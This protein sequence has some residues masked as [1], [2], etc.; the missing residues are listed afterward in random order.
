RAISSGAG[1]SKTGYTLT[2]WTLTPNGTTSDVQP[3]ESLDDIETAGLYS[4]DGTVYAYNLAPS[5]NVTIYAVWTANTYNVTI[6]EKGGSDISDL[7]SVV[8]DD[9]IAIE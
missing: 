6:D 2:G 8:Y 1:F 5:G 7:S 9:I 3:I 4:F